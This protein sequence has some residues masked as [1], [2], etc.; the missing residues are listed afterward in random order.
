M[1][2]WCGDAALSPFGQGIIPTYT[3]K[4]LI[5]LGVENEDLSS[6]ID[7]NHTR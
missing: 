7:L 2:I 1:E 4:I 3:Q 5:T 6:T